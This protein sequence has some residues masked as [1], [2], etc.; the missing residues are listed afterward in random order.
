M[1]HGSVAC[2]LMRARVLLSSSLCAAVGVLR[3]EHAVKKKTDSDYSS[4]NIRDGDLVVTV[5]EYCNVSD[6]ASDLM[7]KLGD[8]SSVRKLVL[9]D[10]RD[11]LLTWDRTR[12]RCLSRRRRTLPR[13]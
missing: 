4:T 8:P 13:T 10:F 11:D 12:S 5:Y 7:G 2:V 9:F 1:D 3:L 6:T